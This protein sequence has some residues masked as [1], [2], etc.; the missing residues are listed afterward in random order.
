ME[1]ST[2]KNG[3]MKGLEVVQFGGTVCG[4]VLGTVEVVN[5]VKAYNEIKII[6]ELPDDDVLIEHLSIKK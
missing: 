6:K 4:L 1:V 5:K 2:I 3:V